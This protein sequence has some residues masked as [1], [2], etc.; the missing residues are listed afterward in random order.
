MSE[1]I[2]SELDF[3][4]VVSNHSTI[5]YRNV[6]P[7]GSNSVTT[8][9]TSTVGPTEF[10]IPSTCFNL[11]KSRLNFNITAAAGGAGNFTHINGNLLTSIS[12]IT[13]YDAA[14]NALW[15]DISNVNSYASLVVPACTDF[16]DFSTK[17]FATTN[18]SEVSL[19]GAQS[20]GVE[21]ISKCN[22]TVG[23]FC[24]D[25][26]ATS[27]LALQNFYFSRRQYYNQATADTAAYLDV[28]IP[29]SAFKLSVLAADKVLYSPS[30]L[31]LQVY[32]N[33]VNNYANLGTNQANPNTGALSVAT[34]FVLGNISLSL[35]CEANLAVVSQIINK[36]MTS[37]VSIPIAY[38]TVTRQSL[39][40]ATSQSYQL[41]ITSGYGQ[42]ILALFTAPFS[43]AAGAQNTNVHLRGPLT[44]YNTFLNNVPI[45]T[46]SGF[47]AS[48][49]Q[50]YMIANREYLEGSV[51]QC[52]GEYIN[53][54]WV[55]IDNFTGCKAVKD[56]NQ[57]EIDGL[58]VM[59]QSSTWQIQ[60]NQSGAGVG[61][62]YVTVIVGQK[63]LTISNQG[64]LIQ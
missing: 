40:A 45:L 12:R 15:A 47:D 32:W 63:Q 16:K 27:D 24:G 23:N 50:D 5:V 22:L 11:A 55:H 59:G 64:S 53:G 14:T 10:I 39:G 13:L 1:K 46:A 44:T 20:K 56:I 17:A 48:K 18:F 31:C 36:V 30:S 2:S 42:R 57:H 38:P 58:S 28:S 54:E 4:P 7:Q 62:A 6:A 26:A 52:N 34:A 49:N 33:A 37:G 61:Y 29:L 43:V 21:D 51:I 41:S 25:G 3:S 9:I 8:S 60:A 35:A 19:A